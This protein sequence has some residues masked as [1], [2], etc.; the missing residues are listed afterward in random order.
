MDF[1]NID[2]KVLL[3]KV[4]PWALSALFI[5]I[6]V[7]AGNI[8]GKGSRLALIIGTSEG[9]FQSIGSWFDNHLDPII[10][11]IIWIVIIIMATHLIRYLVSKF[12]IFGKKAKTAGKL[13]DSLIKYISFFALVIII[14]VEWGINVRSLLAGLGILALLLGLGAQSLIADIV[15]GLFIVFEGDYQ[16]GDVVVLDDYRGTVES[17]GLRTTKI[18]DIAGNVKIINNSEIRSLINMTVDLSVAVVDV[19]IS[20]DESI[21]QVELVI[22]KNIERIQKQVKDIIEGPFYKGVNAFKASGIELRFVAKVDEENRYQVERDLR[23]QIKIIFDEFKISIPYQT[24]TIAN[25]NDSEASKLSHKDKEKVKDFLEE[26]KEK[27]KEIS[28]SQ[29]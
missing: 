6:L 13:I 9:G 23:R 11:S 1:K 18:K 22:G 28:E 19:E 4:L 7:F 24:V 15:S 25:L 14:L 17:I 21:E 5:L 3:K 10:K 29:N 27:S 16:V 20:Y 26:Q 12:F 2:K 8:F